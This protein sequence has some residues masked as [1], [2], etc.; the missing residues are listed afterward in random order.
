MRQVRS[1][2][3]DGGNRLAPVPDAHVDVDSECLDPAS[4]PLQLLDKFCIALNWSHLG[5]SPV[6]D[7]MRSGTGQ[8]RTA[9]ARDSLKLCDCRSKILLRLRHSGADTCDHLHRGLHE[10]VT[11]LL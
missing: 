7:G 4:Q 2:R 1:E 11:D 8:H 5:I 10:L 9:T 3:I 6:A